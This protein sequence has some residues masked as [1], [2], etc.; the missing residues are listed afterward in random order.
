M[1]D[2]LACHS[3][4]AVPP[5]AT[6]GSVC[7]ERGTLADTTS[8]PSSSSAQGR[9]RKPRPRTKR[10]GQAA[11]AP[12]PKTKVAELPFTSREP[13]VAASAESSNEG[14]TSE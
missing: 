5:S 2:R 12:L 11:S 1:K 10:R 9:T 7:G 13:L 8:A 3:S 4:R 14:A 6:H